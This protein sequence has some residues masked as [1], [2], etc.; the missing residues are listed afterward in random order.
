MGLELVEGQLPEPRRSPR[1]PRE[2]LSLLC[3]LRILTTLPG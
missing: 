1:P 3:Q 2:A